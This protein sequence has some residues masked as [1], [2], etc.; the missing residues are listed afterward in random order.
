MDNR[1]TPQSLVASYFNALSKGEFARAWSYWD[2]EIAGT[3][4][5]SFVEGF[6]NTQSIIF[7]LGQP[8]SEGAA[9]SIFTSIPLA[10]EYT[11]EDGWK[12][13]YRG[14]FLVRIAIP[15]IQNPPFLGHHFWEGNFIPVDTEFENTAP[16][17]C[18]ELLQK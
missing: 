10:V 2:N 8:M 3:N 11:D 1:S 9:G 5:E 13:N 18:D 6:T 14:C 15:D 16:G 17:I 4:F 7:K 12:E